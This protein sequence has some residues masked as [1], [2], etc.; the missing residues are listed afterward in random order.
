VPAPEQNDNSDTSGSDGDADVSAVCEFI[1]GQR[2]VS[3]G[4]PD[5]D[6][7]CACWSF[8]VPCRRR[9]SFFEDSTCWFNISDVVLE[10]SYSCE[11]TAVSADFPDADRFNG[12]LDPVTGVLTWDGDLYIPDGASIGDLSV[13]IL[14]VPEQLAPCQSAAL[15]AEVIGAQG[16]VTYAWNPSGGEELSL[17]PDPDSADRVTITARDFFCESGLW[18]QVTDEAGQVA[19]DIVSVYGQLYRKCD[20]VVEGLW[21]QT[22]VDPGTQLT[23]EAGPCADGAD[24][25]TW[26]QDPT[27]PV[28]LIDLTDHGDGSFSFVVPC[29]HPSV[30]GHSWRANMLLTAAFSEDCEAHLSIPLSFQMCSQVE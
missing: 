21:S 30:N 13:Q 23:V 10:G 5:M 22:N 11:D 9:L 1:S 6:S 8:V 20:A 26:T 17:E 25:I 18:V 7:F 27:D 12:I 3:A 28:Q 16:D 4:F 24:S 19:M 29:A 2:F 15:Q 14:D